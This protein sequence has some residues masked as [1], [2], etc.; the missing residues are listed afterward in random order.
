MVADPISVL[1]ATVN[2]ATVGVP[3][4]SAGRAPLA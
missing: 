3:D 2:T 4:H 1:A